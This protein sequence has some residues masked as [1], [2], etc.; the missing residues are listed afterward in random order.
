[1]TTRTL[2][3]NRGSYAVLYG[4]GSCA[5]PQDFVEPYLLTHSYG[6][7]DALNPRDFA[8]VFV[9]DVRAEE[10]VQQL[11]E[12]LVRHRGIGRVVALQEKFVLPAARLRTMFGL[13][14]TDLATATRFRD[15]VL[16]KD[17]MSRA[18]IPVPRYQA[19]G[20]AAD[21]ADLSWRADRLVLKPRSGLGG[22][23]VHVLN[24]LA[25]CQ[26]LWA[27]LQLTGIDFE[28]EEFIYGDIYH[29]DA[30]RQAG[31]LRHCF[32][33]QYIGRPNEFGLDGF[34]ASRLVD[35]PA[36][37]ARM[38]AFTDEVLGA[39]GLVDGVCHLELFRTPSDG[40]VLCEVACRP[41]GGLVCETIRHSSGIDLISAAI[42]VDAGIEYRPEAEM[43]GGQ[44]RCWG[45]VSVYSRSGS[46]APVPPSRFA[47]LGV[48]EHRPGSGRGR[49]P[50][51]CTDYADGYV[52][53]AAD[54][55]E[56]LFRLGQ[57]T[58][59]GR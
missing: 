52:F 51:H 34:L 42:H 3:M 12:W 21:L 48:V 41:S 2:I 7:V 6:G 33:S 57:L 15:K 46:A 26:R 49:A 16:M 23:D 54:E 44:R 38:T 56:W 27:S 25:D 35:D 20:S 8:E 28:V 1:M 36:L 45:C 24:S 39:L 55:D 4:G 50:R 29:C 37:S 14:G 9:V 18:G 10:E 31:Q 40:L 32:V 19:I 58:A 22:N 59:G 47:E 53:H 30:V 5:V 13:A 43:V 11:S 17:V